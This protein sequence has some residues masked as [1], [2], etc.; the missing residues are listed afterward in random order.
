MSSY[1]G[2]SRGHGCAR[3]FESSTFSPAR[4]YILCAIDHY[5]KRI[6][7]AGIW[8]LRQT[9]GH[10]ANSSHGCF[11]GTYVPTF[12]SIHLK[13]SVAEGPSIALLTRDLLLA[14]R[15][16]DEPVFN[17]VLNISVNAYLNG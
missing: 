13:L 12:L 5:T 3:K 9:P 17:A 7:N 16:I 2:G 8:T 1:S 6:Y 15:E 4:N 14:Y 11:H 10:C